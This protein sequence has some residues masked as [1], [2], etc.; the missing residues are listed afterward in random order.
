MADDDKVK[1]V[2]H[3]GQEV[4]T[5]VGAAKMCETL[6]NLIEDAGTGAPIPLPNV[7]G[8]MLTKVVEYC[9]YHHEHP[10]PA[11]AEGGTKDQER[12][13]D[14]LPWD[15]AYTET[16]PQSELFDLILAANYLDIRAL[17]DLTCKVVANMIKG[18][19]PAEI[20]A[21]FNVTE[22]FTPEEREQVIKE[23]EWL[24]ER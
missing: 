15:L 1:L 20:R 16:M 18:K 12:T 24:E 9:V 3:D 22:D 11:A 10:T 7:S 21:I 6:R 23:N 17:L 19:T 5:T 8:K 13:D 4:E 2:S 14:I